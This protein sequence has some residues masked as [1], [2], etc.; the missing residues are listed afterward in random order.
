MN[1]IAAAPGPTWPPSMCIAP[2]CLAVVSAEAVSPHSSG[3]LTKSCG[4]HRTIR[5]A[6][7]SGSWTM[8][9]LIAVHNASPDSRRNIRSWACPWPCA[10]QLAQ[11]DRDL[12]LHCAAQGAYPPND[13]SPL[14]AVKERLLAFQ[15]HYEADRPALRVEIHSSRP[16]RAAQEDQIA[17]RFP[18]TTRGMS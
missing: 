2:R 13:F 3:W 4:T 17:F 12:L 6:G 18:G 10:C 8:A 16:C 15:A 14:A 9:A 11:S 5:P 7:F 1:T